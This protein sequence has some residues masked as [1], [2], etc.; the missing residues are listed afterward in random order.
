MSEK[1]AYSKATKKRGPNKS[2]I[3]LSGPRLKPINILAY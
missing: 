2:P 3:E 1:N